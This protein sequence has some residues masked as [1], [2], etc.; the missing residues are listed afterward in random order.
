M[1]LRVSG[2]MGRIFSDTALGDD[3]LVPDK[4]ARRF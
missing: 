1:S 2:F 4:I 3:S